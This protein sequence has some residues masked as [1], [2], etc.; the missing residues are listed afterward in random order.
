MKR[1]YDWFYI[2]QKDQKF[3]LLNVNVLVRGHFYS[4]SWFKLLQKCKQKAVA[5]AAAVTAMAAV[6]PEE[7]VVAKVAIME[8]KM[9]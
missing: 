9:A 2:K 6:T 1:R 5:K 7:T 4:A 3:D 8:M